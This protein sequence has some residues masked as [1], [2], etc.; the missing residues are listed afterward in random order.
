MVVHIKPL[1][2]LAKLLY[3]FNENPDLPIKLQYYRVLCGAA[4]WESVGLPCG[5]CDQ[6]ITSTS[7]R[8]Q[9]LDLISFQ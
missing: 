6:K 5:S 9:K 8:V 1:V 4:Q 2:F 3:E 7:T